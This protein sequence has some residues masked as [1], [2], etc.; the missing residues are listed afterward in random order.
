MMVKFDHVIDYGEGLSGV[1]TYL[2]LRLPSYYLPYLLPVGSFGA[3][4]LCLGL[5]ARAFEILAA[6]TSGIAPAADRRARARHRVRVLAARAVPERD[7]RAPAPRSG[8]TAGTTAG[9]VPV[10]RRVLVP[11]RE[12]AVRGPG[13]RSRHPDTPGC[14]DLRARRERAALAPRGGRRR[15]HR[16]RSPLAP[17]ERALPRVPARRSGGRAAHRAARVRVVRARR[18]RAISRCWAPTRAASRSCACASTSA[19]S[20]TRAAT[21]RAT[22]RSGTRGWPTRSRCSCSPCSERRSDSRWSARAASARRRS[23]A[24]VCSAA[25]TRSRRPPV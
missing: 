6:K 23:R 25:T 14:R 5:P 10:E 9:A 13:R 20:T 11:A 24:S 7:G 4:F 8:S 17:R 3:A 16:G 19:R 2:F 1:A 21:P 15:A 18:A 12:Y 22:A